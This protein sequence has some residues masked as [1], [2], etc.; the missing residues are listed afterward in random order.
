MRDFSKF[1]KFELGMGNR[2]NFRCRYCFE[3]HNGA[4]CAKTDVTMEQLQRFA[5][6]IEFIIDKLDHS[7]Q[8]TISAFG[9]ET[10]LYLDK[11]LP[12]AYRLRDKLVD[13]SIT[14]NG[15]LVRQ[16]LPELLQFR[17]LYGGRFTPIISYDFCH[18]DI[19][20]QEGT[21]ALVRENMRVLYARRFPTICL[22][23]FDEEL[24]SSIDVRFEDFLRLKEQIPTLVCKFNLSRNE[25]VFS[26][27]DEHRT[28]L[29]LERV[30]KHLDADPDLAQSFIYNPSFAY[31]TN[32]L[33]DAFFGGTIIGMTLSGEIYP[34][35]DVPFMSDFAQRILRI[36]NIGDSF[37]QLEQHR[38]RLLAELPW[39]PPQ[40]CYKCTAVCRV[41]P[42]QYLRTDVSEYNSMPD[43]HHCRVHKLVSE[44]ITY[45]R[46]F[47]E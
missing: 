10:M 46:A 23:T 16:K 34:G 24:I 26:R 7:Y 39:E 45:S 28:R 41:L 1:Y 42:W 6:Y 40:K 43:E 5:S 21:Y 11:L 22:T 25:G 4:S 37:E 3:P 12:F 32:R 38:E 30:K 31:R 18:Q 8:H 20:R 35:Y 17:K 36:G 14:S 33:P 9:G 44:Y 29:A 2:C 27:M 19:T 13:F 15:S 47:T